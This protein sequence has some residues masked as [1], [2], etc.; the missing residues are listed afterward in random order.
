MR[1]HNDTGRFL[2]PPT[3]PPPPLPSV[4]S[5]L[6]LTV[7]QLARFSQTNVQYAISVFF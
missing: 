1:M 7:V 4:S 5:S 6:L 3:P 2:T